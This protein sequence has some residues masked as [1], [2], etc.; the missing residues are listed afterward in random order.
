MNL[1]RYEGTNRALFL[2]VS[3]FLN[4]CP[5]AEHSSRTLITNSLHV[6]K[7][8]RVEPVHPPSIVQQNSGT[9]K[10]VPEHSR[11]CLNILAHALNTRERSWAFQNVPEHSR[12]LLNI[13]ERSWTFRNVPEHSRIPPIVTSFWSQ[14][15]CSLLSSDVIEVSEAVCLE[16]E[17]HAPAFDCLGPGVFCCPTDSVC[18][19]E[20]STTMS[21]MKLTRYKLNDSALEG[22]SVPSNV[23]TAPTVSPRRKLFSKFRRVKFVW[24]GSGFTCIR[25][26]DIRQVVGM[27]VSIGKVR[28]DVPMLSI[29]RPKF[30]FQ[31]CCSSRNSSV[32]VCSKATCES[33]VSQSRASSA[34]SGTC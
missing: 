27:L 24:H 21:E 28:L 15:T 17:T 8:S 4:R 34:S 25:I 3:T 14:W 7:H 29:G 33:S 23:K 1:Q 9:F 5:S 10:I 11:T 6:P 30:G 12:T 16:A 19:C 13:Q 2:N 32:Q 22:S 20:T 26:K 18:L 31:F